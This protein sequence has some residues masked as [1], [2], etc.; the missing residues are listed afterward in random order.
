MSVF[1]PIKNSLKRL[2][3]GGI[4]AEMRE[5]IARNAGLIK[6]MNTKDQLEGDG[7]NSLGV[8]INSYRDYTKFTKQIKKS[9]G[10]P[11]DRVTLKDTGDFHKRFYIELDQDGFRIDSADAKRD[12]LVKKYGVNIFGLTPDN[13][14][15]LANVL[16]IDLIR[17]IK[18]L[19]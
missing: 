15:I 1:A 17:R 11:Y 9:K 14:R 7:V 4:Q 3:Q 6:K 19:I 18:A 13:K 5:A 12:K 16:R 10:D 2:Q 8:D